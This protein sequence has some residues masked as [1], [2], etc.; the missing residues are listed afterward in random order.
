VVHLQGKLQQ[1]MIHSE[2]HSSFNEVDAP[3]KQ[4]SGTGSACSV[5]ASNL[6]LKPFLA[7]VAIAESNAYLAY[8]DAIEYISSEYSHGDLKRD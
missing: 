4:A 3:N 2:Y 7:L 8:M 5:G 1:P 6:P